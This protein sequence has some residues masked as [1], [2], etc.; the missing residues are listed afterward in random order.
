VR[1]LRKAAPSGNRIY[2]QVDSLF[3]LLYNASQKFIVLR[4]GTA[5]VLVPNL[6]GSRGRSSSEAMYGN[7]QSSTQLGWLTPN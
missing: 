4:L 2:Q 3:R 6:Y 7:Y 5:V 1:R